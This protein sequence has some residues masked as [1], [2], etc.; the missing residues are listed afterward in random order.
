MVSP[1]PSPATAISTILAGYPTI[2][3]P[4]V[5]TEDMV[6]QALYVSISVVQQ[7][8]AFLADSQLTSDQLRYESKLLPGGSIGK[9]LRHAADHYNLLV[10]AA[11]TEPPYS[12][13][14]DIRVRD[15]A[16]ETS[17]DSARDAFLTII[18]ALKHIVTSTPLDA[19]I[20]LHAMTP[21]PAVMN[22][23]FG[24]ELWFASLH[25]IHHWSM[26]RV[27]AAEQGI[28]A[29]ESFGFAPSTLLFRSQSSKL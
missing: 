27:I 25:A 26:V 11:S 16:V 17:T 10:K 19:P 1:L 6:D 23:T 14:Y 3:P 22:T 5:N 29:D 12:L 21:F 8:L 9:H 28:S 4:D 2:S 18:G 24:R 13:S 7:A 15:T 20:M